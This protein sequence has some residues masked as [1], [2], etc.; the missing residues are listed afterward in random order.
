M[1]YPFIFIS[2]LIR[3][4][5]TLMLELLTQPPYSFIFHEPSLCRDKFITKDKNLKPI[6][7][8]GID[9][10]STLKTPILKSF[11]EDIMPLLQDHIMQ[12]GVKEVW[13][14]KWRNYI[15][16]FPN[17]KI[18]IMGRD[19]RDLYISVY[20]W[21]NRNR[22][23]PRPLTPRRI[24]LLEGEMRKQREIFK[25]GK[26]IK[27]RYEDLC[28]KQE[29]TITKI[30]EFINSPIPTTGNI[31]EF[32]S[33]LTKRQREYKQHGNEITTSS[34]QRWK[35]ETNKNLVKLANN[36]FK[37]IPEYRRFWGY[38]KNKRI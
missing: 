13:S 9:I 22:K 33:S 15:N 20:Y 1:K 31:G 5:S 14:S 17:T 11:K 23:A 19:P 16:T 35:K 7:N 32:L 12:I 30:K 4:G 8:H 37:S 24:R 3:S 28:I 6:L 21:R 34:I 27:V 10:N 29:E 26:A 36:F 18:I 38:R 25:T 2:S